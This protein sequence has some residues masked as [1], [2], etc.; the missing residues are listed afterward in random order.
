MSLEAKFDRA[1]HGIYKSAKSEAGYNATIFLRMLTKH[2]G[3]T[4]AK[5]LINATSPSEGYT[6]LYELG[7]LHLTVEA[8]VLENREF[9]D[10]F[11]PEELVRARKRLNDYGY[12]PKE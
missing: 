3:V 4:T 12:T 10:L 9:H 7:F 8:V 1:M 11:E 2:S 5:I 6:K